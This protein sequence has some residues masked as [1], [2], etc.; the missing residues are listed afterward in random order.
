M[1]SIIKYIDDYGDLSIYQKKVNDID[2]L[3]FSLIP[4][5]NFKNTFPKSDSITLYDLWEKAKDI[6]KNET[7]FSAKI[8]YKVIDKMYCKN[9][10]KD[11][12]LKNYVYHLAEDTQFGAITIDTINNKYVAFE[13]TD[14]TLWGWK[15]NFKLTYTYPTESQELAAKY[16]N[17]AINLFGP[18]ITV[19]GHSK[20][21]NLALVASMNIS[22]VKKSK[23][24]KIYSFDGP[25]LKD[26]EFNSSNYLLVKRKL[27]NIIP[28]LSIVG[29]LLNQENLT[30]IKSNGIGIFQHNPLTWIINKDRF[31]LAKQDKLSK[32]LDVSISK[33]LA[34]YNFTE[35]EEVIEGVFKIFSDADIKTFGDIK[36][37]KF[38]AVKRIIKSSKELSHE[39][40]NVIL[41]CLKVFLT[42][43]SK[44]IFDDSINSIEN[45]LGLNKEKREVK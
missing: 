2:I 37:Q 38:E 35:R 8:A 1:N 12:L 30:V 15:E 39:T 24:K 19:C 36:S 27:V 28:N 34:K 20:G 21:G 43:F 10:Y 6:N 18:N 42:G 33:W 16:L 45:I 44:E 31:M 5:L 9:R 4:Y 26:E 29:I 23:I 32:K 7:S 40:K 14:S 3:I 11:L 22:F 41:D 17:D 13:G 25:G